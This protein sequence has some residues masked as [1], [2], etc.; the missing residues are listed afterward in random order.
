MQHLLA[1]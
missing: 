1:L